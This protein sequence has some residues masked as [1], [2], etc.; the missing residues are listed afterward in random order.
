M[1]ASMEE[2]VRVDGCV[3]GMLVSACV[4]GFRLQR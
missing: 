2:W 3:V 1:A 4:S